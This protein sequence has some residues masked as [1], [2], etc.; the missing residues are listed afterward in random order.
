[1]LLSY[2]PTTPFTETE[3]AVDS[4]KGITP[5]EPHKMLGQLLETYKCH[6]PLNVLDWKKFGPEKG[7]EES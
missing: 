2:K 5:F 3:A 1:M 6:E 4:I 7:T